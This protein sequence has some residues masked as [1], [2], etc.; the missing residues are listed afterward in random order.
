LIG[1]VLNTRFL[2]TILIAKPRELPKPMMVFH[3]P[4]IADSMLQWNG[5]YFDIDGEHHRVLVYGV[6]QSG[7]TDDLTRLHEDATASGSHFIDRASR[8]SAL[9]AL[10][11][12]FAH[13]EA[14]ILEIGC[15]GGHLLRDMLKALPKARLIGGDYTL[16]TLHQLAQNIPPHIP[17][18]RFDLTQCPLPSD[19]VDGAV[20][21]NVLEH[22]DDHGAAMRHL[23]RII[24]P[25][26]QVVIEVPAGPEL[27]DDYDREL[28]HFRRYT[29]E[30]LTELVEQ[31]GFEIISKNYLGALLYPAFRFSKRRSQA[32]KRSAADRAGHV[33]NA[34]EATSRFNGIGATL[35]AAEAALSTLITF[36]K[37][38]RCVLT[39]R[40]P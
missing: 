35:M 15:S 13:R 33:Q 4:H 11:T 22:I 17:L 39:A 25:G 6:G 5:A 38:I 40:R 18:I 30:S 1:L 29:L 19:S 10:K 14:T 28:L 27:F 26:G 34:I 12:A 7:W 20:L 9:K 37:G 3:H 31:A 16:N 8:A 36:P 23:A 32:R 2:S 21:L 24:R